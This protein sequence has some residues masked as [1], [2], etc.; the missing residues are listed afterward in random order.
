M[1]PFNIAKWN[2]PRLFSA[3]SELISE[4][5]LP[6]FQLNRRANFFGS[7]AVKFLPKCIDCKALVRKHDNSTYMWRVSGS[8]VKKK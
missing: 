1:E 7:S 5:V 8:R 2:W 4:I 3:S 6:S